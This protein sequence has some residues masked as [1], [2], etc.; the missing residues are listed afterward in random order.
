MYSF[1]A[2]LCHVVIRINYCNNKNNTAFS[3]KLDDCLFMTQ[4]NQVKLQFIFISVQT[5]NHML[6]R[7]WR[8]LIEI[9]IPKIWL[10]VNC[11]IKSE[12]N[13]LQTTV[14]LWF[15]SKF[16]EWYLFYNHTFHKVMSLT[17]CFPVVFCRCVFNTWWSHVTCEAVYLWF[18]SNRCLW[19]ISQLLQSF[20]VPFPTC[21]KHFG[22]KLKKNNIYKK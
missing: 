3:Y 6:W 7:L 2:V 4:V 21:L 8:H 17:P 16:E 5:H 20:V 1:A 11:K 9:Q 15:Y 14:V 13:Q 22:I 10:C 19:S 18:V 12:W